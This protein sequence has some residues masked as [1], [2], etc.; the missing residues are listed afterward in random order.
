[1]KNMRFYFFLLAIAVIALIGCNKSEQP[2][3]KSQPKYP[4]LTAE[5]LRGIPDN[6][7]E[8]AI[9]D[10]VNSKIGDDYEHEHQIVTLLSKGFQTVY[11]TSGVEDE[12]NNGGFNQYFWNSAGQFR[13]EALEGYK[14]LGAKEHAEL[15]GEAIKIYGQETERLKKFKEKGTIQAFMESYK[16]DPLKPC[17][18]KFQKIKTDV[19]ALRIKFIRE[20]SELFVGN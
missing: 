14:M 6:E 18:E 8:E 12:V 11:S 10:Y 16:D 3:S 7:L 15:M 4:V 17:D 5:I 20:H 19:S 9:L 1:M 2:A 13:V